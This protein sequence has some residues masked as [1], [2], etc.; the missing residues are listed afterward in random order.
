MP[1]PVGRAVGDLVTF[2]VG[3]L[4]VGGWLT[5]FFVGAADVGGSVG[6]AVLRMLRQRRFAASQ[7][8]PSAKH[9]LRL[10]CDEHVVI[11]ASTAT[12]ITARTNAKRT[13]TRAIIFYVCLVLAGG[14]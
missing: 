12:A 1:G 2:L 14:G 6:A 9:A 5:G 4:V 10:G 7:R 8:Q 13:S 11:C 3:A